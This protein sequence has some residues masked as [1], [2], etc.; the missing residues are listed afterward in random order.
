MMTERW[1][2]ELRTLAGVRP[3]ADLWE[4]ALG[5]SRLPDPA[6]HPR[7]S[8]LLPAAIVLLI[9]VGA[10]VVTWRAFS[11]IHPGPADEPL[12]TYADPRFGWTL[13]VPRGLLVREFT[14]GG[15]FESSGLMVSNFPTTPHG[16]NGT[17]DM[18]GL[19]DFPATGVA[20][21]IWFGQRLP[22]PP[23]PGNDP[24]P[25]DP[26]SF[27]EIRPYV[28]GRE[29]TPLYVTFAEDGF[30]FSAAM[31][32]GPDASVE[33][34]MAIET[35][36]RSLEF[37]QLREG[38][39]WQNR[40]YVLG[41]ADRYAVGSVTRIDASSLPQD[42]ESFSEPPESFFL[43]TRRGA[44][45]W[46]GAWIRRRDPTARSGSM[47]RRSSSS[48]PHPGSGGTGKDGPSAESTPSGSTS[49]PMP[50]SWR[51]TAT[52]CMALLRSLGRRNAGSMGVGPRSVR[53]LSQRRDVRS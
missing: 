26:R 12:V 28:G 41:P 11:S 40:Y 8:R 44:S 50:R 36:L 9:L 14:S 16:G 39:I 34:R 25:L 42:R 48:A 46:S 21:Q 45:T 18:S 33:D 49:V 31:W 27:R 10:G 37:P 29:P 17:P 20:V 5:G 23:P 24:L 32:F 19:R 2:H 35:V 43:L 52:S 47:L 15:F 38:T 6:P 22:V 51:S 3:A 13:R 30:Y 4:R 7:R 53:D 1:E